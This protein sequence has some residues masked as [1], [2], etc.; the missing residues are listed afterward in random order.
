MADLMTTHPQLAAF[1]PELSMLSGV[2]ADVDGL[3]VMAKIAEHPEVAAK[4]SEAL[5]SDKKG[6]AIRDLLKFL[7]FI[8]A[9]LR[10]QEIDWIAFLALLDEILNPA[11]GAAPPVAAPST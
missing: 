10:G 4:L 1:G 11:P 9:L 5:R 8:L 7:P 6:F 3:K 2:T